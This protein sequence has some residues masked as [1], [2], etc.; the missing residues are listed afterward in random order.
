[1]SKNRNTDNQFAFDLDDA[2]DLYKTAPVATS[3][4]NTSLALNET[5]T[6]LEL[7]G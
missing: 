2:L 7:L 6:V 5:T 4:R 1:M 3:D